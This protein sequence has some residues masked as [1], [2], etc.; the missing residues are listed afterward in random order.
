MESINDNLI[1]NKNIKQNKCTV[2]C[3]KVICFLVCNGLFFT[4]GYLFNKYL[5]FDI[6]MKNSD[7]SL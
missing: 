6:E 4:G 3:Y 1:D 5:E 2:K 7:G